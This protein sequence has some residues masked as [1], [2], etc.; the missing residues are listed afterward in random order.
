MGAGKRG[1][2][3]GR[4]WI[5]VFGKGGREGKADLGKVNGWR[6]SERELVLKDIPRERLGDTDTRG[7][8]GRRIYWVWL[9]GATESERDSGPVC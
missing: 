9:E 5:D 6:K 7:K 3:E 4:G 2:G 1:G 8:R